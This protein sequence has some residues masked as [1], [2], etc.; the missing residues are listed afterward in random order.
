MPH[1]RFLRQSVAARWPIADWL[2]ALAHA[3]AV[4][5][6]RADVQFSGEGLPFVFEVEHRG[7][8]GGALDHGF[9]HEGDLPDDPAGDSVQQHER[10]ADHDEPLD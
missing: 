2:L 3:K 1:L 8:D 10:H 7:F 9:G 4:A 5:A 6:L